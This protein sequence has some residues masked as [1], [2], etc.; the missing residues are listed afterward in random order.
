M[1]RVPGL[2]AP[3]RPLVAKARGLNRPAQPNEGKVM[4]VDEAETLDLRCRTHH[5][6]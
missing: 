5:M 1:T 3:A 4:E 2:S 6:L